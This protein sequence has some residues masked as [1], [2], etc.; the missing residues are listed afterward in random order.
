MYYGKIIAITIATIT[1][2][3]IGMNLRGVLKYRKAKLPV[4][5]SIKT[6][7]LGTSLISLVL[8]QAA[9]LAFA[10]DMQNPSANGMLGSLLWEVW[11]PSLGG[12]LAYR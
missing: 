11:Q 5:H 2:T 8:T 10:D 6:I 9:I 1:F 4:L 3:E 7:S 12:D